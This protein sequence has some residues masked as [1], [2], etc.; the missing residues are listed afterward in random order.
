MTNDGVKKWYLKH[1]Q[2]AANV[3]QTTFNAL[4]PKRKVTSPPGNPTARKLRYIDQ[5]QCGKPATAIDGLQAAASDS[6]SD[7]EG[8]PGAKSLA[9][10]KGTFQE[11]SNRCV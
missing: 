10:M 2:T 5:Q 4:C 6:L 8:L 3:L 7:Q 11:T 9:I 1:L